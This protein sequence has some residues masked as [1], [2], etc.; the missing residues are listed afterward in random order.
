[1]T[2]ANS[3]IWAVTSGGTIIGPNSGKSVNINWISGPSSQTMVV[4]AINACGIS[5]SRALT[6]TTHPCNTRLDEVQKGALDLLV[7][8]NPTA[9]A[10][11]LKFNVNDESRYVIRILDLTGKLLISREGES[12]AGDNIFDIDFS[13]LSA[14]G[15]YLVEVECAGKVERKRVVVER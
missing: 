3:Y 5:N 4:R 6:V 11:V 13:V 8:P 10:A 14:S 1:V 2:G 9:G 7:Y 15:L 12:L